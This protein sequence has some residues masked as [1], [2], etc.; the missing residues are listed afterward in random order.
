MEFTVK[1]VKFK[2]SP[3][4]YGASYLLDIF[5]PNLVVHRRSFNV[6]SDGRRSIYNGF[7]RVAA[8]FAKVMRKRQ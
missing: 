7:S 5:G 1:P 3:L 4:L 8:G 6:E 2:K